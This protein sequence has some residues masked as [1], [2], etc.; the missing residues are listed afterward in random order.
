MRKGII[1]ATIFYGIGFGLTGLIY[2]IFGSGYAHGPGFYII[3]PFLTLLIGLFWTSST[4]YN[5]YF[6]DKTDERRGI[7][8]SNFIAIIIFIIIVFY[9][10]SESKHLDIGETNRD[11][12]DTSHTGDTTSMSYNGT[13]I[14]LKVKDSVHF[15]KRDSLTKTMK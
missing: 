4:L 14:Y 13:I 11:E 5:Y 6:K 3:I 12:I 15:D 10:R 8:Y 1:S 2:L 9:V 7:I